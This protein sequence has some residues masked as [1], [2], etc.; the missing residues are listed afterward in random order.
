MW[1]VSLCPT[2]FYSLEDRSSQKNLLQYYYMCSKNKTSFLISTKV[3]YLSWKEKL[4]SYSHFWDFLRCNFFR[5]W[6][7]SEFSSWWL[8]VLHTMCLKW[9]WRVLDLNSV[10]VVSNFEY[11]FVSFSWLLFGVKSLVSL[12]WRRIYTDNSELIFSKRKRLDW[13]DHECILS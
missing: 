13:I 12:Q 1:K 4:D 11:F 8:K 9:S 5:C 7:L 3:S 6:F 2:H 10:W